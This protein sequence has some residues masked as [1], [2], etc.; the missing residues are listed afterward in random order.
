MHLAWSTATE[1]ANSPSLEPKGLRAL[2]SGPLNTRQAADDKGMANKGFG[3]GV[4]A[5]TKGV[6]FTIIARPHHWNVNTPLSRGVGGRSPGPEGRYRRQAHRSTISTAGMCG[7]AD[8]REQRREIA[9]LAAAPPDVRHVCD[10]PGH[11]PL[12]LLGLRP[13]VGAQPRK[14][15]SGYGPEGPSPSAH[16]AAEPARLLSFA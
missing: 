3:I 13:Q 2:E 12:D 6:Q 11:R 7:E 4:S 10:L 5:F 15:V 16:P 14:K 1:P 8:D 9:D